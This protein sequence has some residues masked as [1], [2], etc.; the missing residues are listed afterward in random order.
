MNG[1]IDYSKGP[2]FK[3]LQNPIKT[4]SWRVFR[5]EIHVRSCTYCLL[6]WLYCPEGC[7]KQRD[8]TLLIDYDYCKGCGI[9]AKECKVGSITM[10]RE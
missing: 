6:C 10:V 3:G 7:I 1:D 5:P 4:G 8:G 9:C 2:T